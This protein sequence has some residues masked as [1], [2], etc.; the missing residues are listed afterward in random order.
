MRA[1]CLILLFSL[2]ALPLVAAEP[3]G[4]RDLEGKIHQPLAFQADKAAVLLFVA[5][6]CPI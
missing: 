5:C 2:L 6:D 1:A 4:W 3:E